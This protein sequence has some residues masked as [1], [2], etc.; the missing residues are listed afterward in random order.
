MSQFAYSI[1]NFEV[2][3]SE[4]YYDTP[5]DLNQEFFEF[6][7]RKDNGSIDT[8]GWHLTTF[9][10]DSFAL[11]SILDLG[12]YDY[13]AIRSGFGI[14]D[15]DASD[16]SAT[17]YLSN[18]IEV[19]ND[20][21]DEIALYDADGNLIDFVRYNGGNSGIVLGG[22]SLA[23]N[24]PSADSSEESVQVHGADL[25]SSE[26]WISASPSAADPNLFET[27]ISNDIV[28]VMQNGIN[29]QILI[30]PGSKFGGSINFSIVKA[31]PAVML[32][33]LKIIEEMINFS[34][35]FYRSKGFND[36]RTNASRIIK[37]TISN[38]HQFA[39]SASPEGSMIVDI[40][41]NL[42]NVEIASFIKW[43]VE[44]EFYHLIAY[45]QFLSNGTP[46]QNGS[47]DRDIVEPNGALA[48][49]D[50][51]AAE[52]WGLEISK[53]QFNVTEEYL[54]NASNRIKG[55]HRNFSSIPYNLSYIL[56]N[57]DFNL[58]NQT[59]GSGVE[60][61]T[62]GF[63]FNKYI[64]ET[65]GQQKIFHIHNA[66]RN[67][68]SGSGNDI[69]GRMAIEK[70][71][72]DEGIDK[73]FEQIFIEYR[74]WIYQ[75]FSDLV[76]LTSNTTFNDHASG[77]SD[78]L[79]PWGSD[80]EK[81]NINKSN[82]NSTG[83]YNISFQGRPGVNYSISILARNNSGYSHLVTV[84]FNGKGIVIFNATSDE[85]VVIK[86]QINNETAGQTS[87]GFNFSH[88]GIINSTVKVV[89]LTNSTLKNSEVTNSTII[90]SS[91]TNSTKKNSIII[92]SIDIGTIL[93]D[94]KENNSKITKSNVSN[95]ILQNA[96]I[97][98]S[99]LNNT[100]IQ[101]SVVTNS[102]LENVTIINSVI[103]NSTKKNSV[104]INSVDTESNVSNSLEN[105]SKVTN[106]N[107]TRSRLQNS[108]IQNSILIN[109]T[110]SHSNIV[111]STLKNLIVIKSTI[112][113]SSF[114]DLMPPVCRL[115]LSKW[116]PVAVFIFNDSGSGIKNIS[117]AVLKGANLTPA[118]PLVFNPPAFEPVFITATR[119]NTSVEVTLKAVDGSGNSLTCDPIVSSLV[120]GTGAPETFTYTNIPE[121]EHIV[122][123]TNKQLGLK[124]LRL[125]VNGKNFQSAGLKDNEVRN[126]DISNAMIQGDSNTVA[127]TALGKP[128]TSAEI[129][130]WDGMG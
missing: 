60:V 5:D 89:T 96:T 24:G 59:T 28:I 88:I 4:I 99:N 40:G 10:N 25:N 14:N 20:S 42:S 69:I 86:T 39:A 82:I 114:V 17:I 126:I 16:G 66:T 100:V 90:G 76:R 33:E 107:V 115:N 64:A 55:K 68:R 26:N 37:V 9:D 130:I 83:P 65:Y 31:S 75:T 127:L 70:A 122:T 12:I 44:H 45:E 128:G 93:I 110:A 85:F 50:E 119:T 29:K 61:Y 52:F 116:P 15:L 72:K 91:I 57:S 97:I 102:N 32:A 77:H 23:D 36:P 101:N 6:T 87:Y 125:K 53:A 13:V 22:W 27:I 120:R 41:D 92:N 118:L 48:F 84:V 129:L 56:N 124:T 95:S 67:N 103:T 43:N 18:D 46:I 35:N 98:N 109:V 11:P 54:F 104:I 21:G 121:A 34:S 30:E 105:N 71:F 3:I 73:S 113:N 79:Q 74:I 38:N 80:Y 117:V 49:M 106:S 123:I 63:I 112:I 47:F 2:L 58:V 94:S 51:G 1:P 78:Q 111:N 81:I 62:H 19:L 7:V 8:N 108:T